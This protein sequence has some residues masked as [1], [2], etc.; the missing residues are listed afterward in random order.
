[1]APAARAAVEER[2]SRRVELKRGMAGSSGIFGRG[3]PTRFCPVTLRA[4]N[5][6]IFTA[7]WASVN[8]PWYDN[9]TRLGLQYTGGDISQYM[10]EEARKEAAQK[11]TL[12]GR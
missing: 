9:V 2:K 11:G 3:R 12:P 6:R 7:G 10:V 1:M 4:A 8:T 5:T